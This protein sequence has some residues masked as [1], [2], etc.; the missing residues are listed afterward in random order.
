MPRR[1]ESRQEIRPQIGPA[2]E[3][4]AGEGGWLSQVEYAPQARPRG[5]ANDVRDGRSVPDRVNTPEATRAEGVEGRA[6]TAPRCGADAGQD[7]GPASTRCSLRKRFASC[8]PESRGVDSSGG[9]DLKS[10]ES[11]FVKIAKRFGENR[12]IGYGAWRDAVFPPSC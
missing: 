4:D 9:G 8:R 3:A 7:R 2:A 1:E 10:L 6:S 5:G 12:G 11:A